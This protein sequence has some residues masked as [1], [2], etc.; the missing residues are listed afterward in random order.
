MSNPKSIKIGLKRFWDDGQAMYGALI[1][2]NIPFCLTLEP[3]KKRTQ[4]GPIPAGVY[5]LRPF[6]GKKY[7]NV[8]I[9]VPT[10]G[11]VGIL[12]HS[13][14]FSRDTKGCILLG[15]CFL[16]GGGI[17]ESI[18]TKEQFRK[19]IESYEEIKLE[20]QE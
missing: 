16:A 12:I 10:P 2:D 8:W 15:R 13:G 18:V 20:I 6:N 5:Q 7:K 17:G 4:F 1:I 14:N 11:R 19:V 3:S 9:V